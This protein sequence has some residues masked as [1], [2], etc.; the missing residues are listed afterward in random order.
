MKKILSLILLVAMII[1]SS[2]TI[3]K[4]A[5]AEDMKMVGTATK[6]VMSADQKSAT[7]T[8]KDTK[9][10]ADVIVIVSDELTLDKFKDKRIVEG[11]EIRCKYDRQGDRNTAKIFKKTAGC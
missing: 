10:G 9:S 7:V 2:L 6:I 5:S 1:F 4:T 8:L 11:D 3:V